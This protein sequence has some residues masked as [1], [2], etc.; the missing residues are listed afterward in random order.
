MKNNTLGTVDIVLINKLPFLIFFHFS[1]KTYSIAW[2][3]LIMHGLYSPSQYNGE[4]GRREGV[5]GTFYENLPKS[6]GNKIFSYICHLWQDKPLWM[7]LKLNGGVI[8]ITILQR[9][10][11]FISLDKANTQKNQVFLLRIFLRNVN[12]SVVTCQ[13]PQIYNSIFRKGFVSVFF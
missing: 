6:C 10:H 8:F 5:E 2:I 12:A 13:Y 1:D 4:E 9:F 3:V 7:K 11:Y